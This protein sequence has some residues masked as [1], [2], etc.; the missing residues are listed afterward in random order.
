MQL[1]WCDWSNGSCSP[2][3]L[4]CAL[5]ACLGILTSIIN[6]MTMEETLPRLQSGNR[7]QYRLLPLNSNV[8]MTSKEQTDSLDLIPFSAAE[9]DAGPEPIG[10]IQ[11][12][13]LNIMVSQHPW[14][15]LGGRQLTR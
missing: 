15:T 8:E 4:P 12:V 6:V 11:A 13:S 1:V 7:S 2:F 3:L 9:K 5:T 14:R 10:D